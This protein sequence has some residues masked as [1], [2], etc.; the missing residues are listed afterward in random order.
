[1]KMLL[2]VM[3]STA[4]LNSCGGEVPLAAIGPKLG[5][6]SC[7][8]SKK[9]CQPAASP[10]VNLQ[11]VPAAIIAGQSATLTWS[12]QNATSLDLEPGI[13]SV[14]TQ[15]SVSVNPSATTT[16]DL[17]ATGA[18]GTVTAS[19]TVTVTAGVQLSP[20]D[21]IQTAV[22]ANP[23]GTTFV[24]AAGIYR[25]QSVVPKDGDVFSGQTGAVMDGAILIGS[26]QQDSAIWV[27][28]VSSVVEQSSYRGVCL[29]QYPACTY[30]EDLFFDS[31]PLV[32][33]AS[34][35]L[36]GPGTWYFDYSS[37]KAYVGSDPSGHVTEMSAVPTAF[38]GNASDVAIQNLTIE[39]YAS[40]AGNGAIQAVSPSGTASTGWVVDSNDIE[41]NHGMGLRISNGMKVTNNKFHDNGQMGLGGSG[42][43]VLIADNEIYKNNYAGYSWGWEAGGDKFTHST[44]LT[45]QGNYAHDNLGPGLWTD[46][47]NSGVLY[48]NNR[49]ARN[50]EAGIL[51]EISYQATIRN[52]EIVDDGFSTAGTSLWYGAGILIS[53]SSNVEVYGNTVTNCMNAIGAI[54]ANRGVGSNGQPYNLTDLSVHDN[55]V[56]QQVNFAEGIVKQSTFDDS[57]YTSWGNHFQNDT[58]TLS[59]LTLPYFFWLGEPW[60]YAQWQEYA[61]EH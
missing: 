3:V 20:A 56:T 2:V 50:V 37:D 54:Q 51:H 4:F 46:I 33:V 32:R 14:P 23:S 57:V 42:S 1:M 60:T 61:A 24:L 58:F 29:P 28:Q 6:T 34:L 30:T 9:N 10:V 45:I 59:D 38:S 17:T 5:G 41:L 49:T 55:T 52:N 27:A 22:S 7:H 44:N 31:Q 35:A 15:G 43:D 48:E 47:E 39:K 19:A 12:S 21:D 18:G 13:G 8:G 16:Y 53:N 11:A 26:W 36:V 25:M 40:M